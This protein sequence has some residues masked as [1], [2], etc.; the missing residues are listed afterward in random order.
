M[1]LLNSRRVSDANIPDLS[2][3]IHQVLHVIRR[4]RKG[5]PL[6]LVCEYPGGSPGP[7]K[8]L[9]GIPVTAAWNHEVICGVTRVLALFTPPSS[10]LADRTSAL[11]LSSV[12]NEL[13]LLNGTLA[14]CA[15]S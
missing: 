9:R 4:E 11:F 10:N 1:A 6:E 8:G 15:T 2:I 13:W 5:T 7:F 12:F 14:R 3:T